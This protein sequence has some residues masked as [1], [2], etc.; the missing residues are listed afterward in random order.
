MKK[1]ILALTFLLLGVNTLNNESVA[2]KEQKFSSV[3]FKSTYK[4]T[5]LLELYTSE[6][7]SSCPPAD[8][9]LSHLKN[10]PDLWKKY[11]PVAF[12]VDYWNNLGWV[13]QLSS[14]EFSKRQRSYSNQ[15]N[16]TTIYTPEF[17]LNGEEWILKNKILDNGNKSVGVLKADLDNVG[18]LM[19]S[20]FPKDKL[21]NVEVNI[22]IL[23][24]EIISKIK[25]G[26]NEGR[27]LTHY[28]SVLNYKKSTM[29][30]SENNFT[31]ETLINVPEHSAK[32]YSL[33]IWV[34]LDNDLRPLQSLGGNLT[35]K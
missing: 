9:W 27:T 6:G 25:A 31:F 16:N 28:F 22:A 23:G 2:N 32:L 21:K 15:W 24:S 8:E 3:I 30:N 17:V 18:R 26:E 1:S 19:V 13:D 4:Q 12:H 10:N 5:Q 34:N 20:F 33:A 29:K 35:V 14:K 11:V 7:C